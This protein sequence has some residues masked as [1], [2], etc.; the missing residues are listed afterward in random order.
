MQSRVP[1]GY[2]LLPPVPLKAWDLTA[3]LKS[4]PLNHIHYFPFWFDT[5]NG[6]NLGSRGYSPPTPVHIKGLISQIEW[7]QHFSH[8][9]F[10]GIFPNSQGQ[11][12]HKILVGSCWISNPSEILWVYLLPSRMKN[13]QSK[14]NELEW[15]QHYSLIFL[16]LKGS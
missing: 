15:S 6:I 4:P 14:M 2:S 12:T 3:L 13:I 10:M 5:F 16:T 11:V 8:Y 1:G 9:K 7:S